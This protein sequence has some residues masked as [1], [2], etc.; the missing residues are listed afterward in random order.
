MFETLVWIGIGAAVVAALAVGFGLGL[1]MTLD[2]L[3]NMEPEKF[4][5]VVQGLRAANEENPGMDQIKDILPKPNVRITVTA[6]NNALLAHDAETGEFIAQGMDSQELILSAL[7][8]FPNKM[9]TIAIE[10][11]SVEVSP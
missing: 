2:A 3:S 6:A 11:N 5:D 7:K 4:I 8:R 1:K 9:F 10:D